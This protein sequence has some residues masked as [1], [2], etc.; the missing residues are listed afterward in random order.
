VKT[1]AATTININGRYADNNGQ[2]YGGNGDLNWGIVSQRYASGGVTVGFGTCQWSW[3]LDD[4]HD[5]GGIPSSSNAQQFTVN[6]LGDLGAQPATLQVGMVARTPKTLDNYGLKPG[7]TPSG[8]DLP[9]NWSFGNATSADV[10][11][12]TGV[13]LGTALGT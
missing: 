7:S 2:D 10:A 12:G 6:L 5:R 9:G 8:S 4:T 11:L 1:L 3:G 13:A